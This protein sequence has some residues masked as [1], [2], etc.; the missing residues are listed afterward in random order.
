MRR[1]VAVLVLALFAP[2]ANAA[3][4]FS[5]GINVGT[6]PRLVAVPGLPVYY[7]PDVAAN[8][9]FYDGLF[10]AFDG[11]AWYDSPWYNGPWLVV[12]PAF[13]PAYVLRVPVAYYRR[14]PPY[15]VH[16]D[17]HAPPHWGE[18]WGPQWEQGRPG[19]NQWNP[20]QAPPRAPLPSYQR[21]YTGNRYPHADAEQ[22]TLREQHYKYA[23]REE[24]TR[25]RWQ[26]PPNQPHQDHT[27]HHP[28]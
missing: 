19:W 21:H 16:W 20:K 3:T 1:C 6:Y 8:Y 27:P 23:P 22:Q 14:P 25:E 4:F 10:W 5:I 11:T 24:V 18:H 13:V 9:F 26:A 17:H 7:G 28:N 2:L 12:Q 15:F